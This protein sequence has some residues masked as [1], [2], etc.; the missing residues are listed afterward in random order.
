MTSRAR[1]ATILVVVAFVAFLLWT[2][3]ASQRVECTVTVEFQGQR[4]TATASAAS[5]GEA[6]NQAQT[7]A[8]GP[9]TSGMDESIACSNRPPVAQQCRPL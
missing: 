3:L 8:C 5:E 1:T 2:T 4:R 7:V 9:I 6:V